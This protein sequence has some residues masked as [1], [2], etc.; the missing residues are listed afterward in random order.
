[1]ETLLAGRGFVAVMNE[2][3]EPL[4]RDVRLDYGDDD[5][6][7][8]ADDD[9]ANIMLNHNNQK[10]GGRGNDNYEPLESLREH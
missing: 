9:G 3:E 2:N 10:H 6:D 8:A 4:G 7:D 5:D 1:V